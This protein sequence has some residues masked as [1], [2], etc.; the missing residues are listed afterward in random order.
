MDEFW[1]IWRDG[2]DASIYANQ[3]GIAHQQSLLMDSAMRHACDFYKNEPHADVPATL[4][5]CH[6]ATLLEVGKVNFP[7]GK[8]KWFG[9]SN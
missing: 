6:P 4:P 9:Q 8:V 3:M 1:K 2:G 5:P 7:F